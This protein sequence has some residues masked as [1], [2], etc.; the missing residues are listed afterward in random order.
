MNSNYFVVYLYIVAT[1]FGLTR[2][3]SSDSYNE[4]AKLCNG[5]VVLDS[6][7]V[8]LLWCCFFFLY[9][10]VS[11]VFC[12][13]WRLFLSLVS[14]FLISVFYYSISCCFFVVSLSTAGHVK[15]N[16]NPKQQIRCII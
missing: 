15:E 8:F 10:F 14:D 6:Y 12:C 9:C 5:S 11:V 7:L 3:S 16:K 2:P 1:C 13:L 4:I